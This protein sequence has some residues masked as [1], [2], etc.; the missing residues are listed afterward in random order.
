MCGGKKTLETLSKGSE[1]ASSKNF[2]ASTVKLNTFWGKLNSRSEEVRIWVPA[3]SNFGNQTSTIMIMYRLIQ[4]GVINLRIIWVDKDPDGPGLAWKKLQILILGLPDTPPT[5]FKIGNTNVYFSEVDTFK[6]STAVTLG[7]TGGWDGN[8]PAI[9]TLL[10][11][12]SF[13]CL[14]PY[15]WT[16]GKASKGTNTMY[17]GGADDP[18]EIE[19]P[20]EADIP[21]KAYYT[22]PPALSD[23]D[24]LLFKQLYPRQEG[25]IRAIDVFLDRGVVEMLPVYFSPGR[26]LDKFYDIFFNLI[27]GIIFRNKVL[28]LTKPTIIPM[29]AGTDPGDYQKLRLL[30]DGFLFNSSGTKIDGKALPRR[31]QYLQTQGYLTAFKRVILLDTESRCTGQNITI[32]VNSGNYD[33]IVCAIAREP[34]V[35]F[36]Y[37]YSRT[38]LLTVLEGMSTAS[39]VLNLGTPFFHLQSNQPANLYRLPPLLSDET[40]FS[41]FCNANCTMLGSTQQEWESIINNT[42]LGTEALPPTVLGRFI[43][44]V[45]TPSSPTY[46]DFST[47]KAFYSD[48]QNDKLL[49]GL[50][51]ILEYI[52]D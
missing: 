5:V 52:D 1:S 22:I 42:E 6:P 26:P 13:C 30:L 38:T 16:G 2:K 14:Q 33:V 24:W 29:L 28:G 48:P 19:F 51:S 37:V 20:K 49:A 17:I 40:P 43:N 44:T 9:C 18:T 45:I 47:M 23:N 21:K 27:S 39:L 32:C 15:Q 41:K 34:K 8:S 31:Y 7:I 25:C 36:D 11:T 12:N 46:I 3:T 35:V 4:M 50:F 10:Q